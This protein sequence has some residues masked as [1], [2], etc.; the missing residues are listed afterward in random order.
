M[1]ELRRRPVPLRNGRL[2]GKGESA[3]I[4]A[5]APKAI[6]VYRTLVLLRGADTGRPPDEYQL[7]WSGDFYD[8]WQ[9]DAR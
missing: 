1:S 9:R 8:V 7:V 6:L 3:P 4:D 2:L 5:F